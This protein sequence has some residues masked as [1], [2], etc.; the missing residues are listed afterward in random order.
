MQCSV[1]RKTKVLHVNLMHAE[2]SCGSLSRSPT[3]GL[4]PW[5][6]VYI[7]KDVPPWGL[8]YDIKKDVFP[9]DPAYTLWCFGEERSVHL[10]HACG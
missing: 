3:T 4:P 1:L 6:L 10:T 8:V 7:K 5:G 9:P 2:T